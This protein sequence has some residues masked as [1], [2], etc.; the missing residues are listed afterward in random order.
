M[1]NR[2]G[3]LPALCRLSLAMLATLAGSIPAGATGFGFQEAPML[4]EKVA[5]GELPPVVDRLPRT[6]VIANFAERNRQIGRY[7]G[8]L[9]TLAARA[10]DLRYQSVNAYTRLV[11]YD[12][13]LRL[14]PDL[15]ESFENDGD[16]VITLTLR[17]GHR[18]SDGHPF[19]TAD[20]RYYWEDIANNKDLSPSGPSEIYIVD[21]KRPKI[22]FLDERRIRYT[23]TAPNPRF[24]PALAMPQPLA[25]FAP[26]H[27]LKQFHAK[28][29]DKAEL[30]ELAAKAKV[31]SWATLHN[32][33]D[34]AYDNSNPDMPVLTAWRVVTPSPATRFVFER[35]PYF[36]RVD[37]EG[38]QLP[39]MDRVL[40]D[41]ASGSLFA[42][43]SNAGEV[44]LMA[45]GLS[46]NDVPVLK[47]G[48]RMQGYKTLLWTL[49]R[50]SAYALYPNLTTNDPV[51]R[52]L[53][54]DVR[55]RRA[56]SAGIDRRILNNAL[57]FGL[58]TEGNN[59]IMPQ[60]PLYQDNF[61]TDFAQYDPR[62][63]NEL[64]DEIG[65]TA[66]D[67]SGFRKLPDGRTL[68][69]IV[70]VDGESSDIIDALQLVTEFWRDIGVKLFVKPQERSI[71]RQ[72]SWA[73][74]TVMVASGGLD[75]AVP[76]AQMPPTELAPVRQ[77]HYSW[78]KW[79]QW[80]ETQGKSGE[81]PDSVLP[82]RLINLYNAWLRTSDTTESARIWTE[83]LSLNAEYQFTIGT[84]GGEMQPIV[85]AGTIRNIPDKGL[86]SWEPTSLLGVYRV[87]EFWFD[88]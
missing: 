59:T 14:T 16:R 20:F 34:A 80:F 52:K 27:Y 57:L 10:R 30:T 51:W 21:G 65:L 5:K 7:G 49:A 55:Y 84:V 73:G 69:I 19:T 56:L 64:L 53:N 33:M 12:H 87:E 85:R 40:V 6:P 70:E 68:E 23:W 43:K 25:A 66:R 60:S 47:E 18:W 32:R 76:V 39:Y 36:H 38:R 83:M 1:R 63:A 86:Y 9:R 45:R 77:E 3:Y 2:T 24:L 13:K 22:E 46:M 71:L 48:E 78:P 26:A 41:I 42:A 11:G 88:R 28:Y 8:E 82:R 72:R 4:A 50:G 75:N 61:R 58:G 79:G 15:V 35:N 62:L 44:D 17:E 81:E 54:R 37:P 31:R 67:S 74:Q 29:R